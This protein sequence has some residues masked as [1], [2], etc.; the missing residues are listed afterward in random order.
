M[1]ELELKFRAETSQAKR[2]IR[3]LGDA[4]EETKESAG[5]LGAAFARLGDAAHRLDSIA[6]VAGDVIRMGEALAEAAA[7]AERHRNAL[8]RLGS[9]YDLVRNATNDMVSA[10]DA[11]RAQESLTQSGMRVTAEQL[12]VITQRAREYA[13]ATGTETTQA[14]DQLTDA[15]RGGEAE[16]LRRFG[17]SLAA[18][19]DRAT[20]FRTA[21]TQMRQAQEG[22]LP[23][24]RTLGE[25]LSHIRRGFT[26]GIGAMA[27]WVVEATGLRDVIREVSSAFDDQAHATENATARVEEGVTRMLSAI[28]T[29]R[30]QLAEA[31]GRAPSTNNELDVAI[32]GN[33]AGTRETYGRIGQVLGRTLRTTDL[34]AQELSQYEA[35]VTVLSGSAQDF[36]DRDRANA[37]TTQAE[38][39]QHALFRLAEAAARNSQN[40]RRPTTAAARTGG[41]SGSRPANDDLLSQFILGGSGFRD[42]MM[43]ANANIGGIGGLLTG[44]GGTWTEE[45]AADAALTAEVQA[46]ADRREQARLDEDKALAESTRRRALEIEQ[47]R[48]DEE[49]AARERNDLQTQL[50]QR[51]AQHQELNQTTA[52]NA[53]G[54]IEG[55]YNTM[56]GALKTH[57][58][59]VIQGKEDVGQAVKATLQ[60]ILLSLAAESATKAIMETAMGFAALARG[61]SSYGADAGAVVSAPMHFTSAAMFAAI[62]GAA[63]LGYAGVSAIG[64]G[65]AKSAG[66]FGAGASPGAAASTRGPGGAANDG[67]NVTIINNV[68]GFA[69]TH[70]GVQNAI[71]GGLEGYVGRGNRVR[72]LQ[73]A[74]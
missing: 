43:V 48:L 21:I 9:A 5:G 22:T 59:A 33:D 10:E 55:A 38:V 28:A 68:N 30:Q 36:D 60:E 57:I 24:T 11:L 65:E 53:A 41:G 72:G 32:L 15:L 14:L 6:S 54:L 46:N 2:D 64:G 45:M 61:A 47:Q 27:S 13:L 16:G 74:A 49:K 39:L 62:A 50:S 17:I 4:A 12:A 52:Q 29:A 44:I 69:M 66:G 56:T 70:E 18:G 25:D 51:F 19:T 26:E 34:N 3:E 71:A 20:A 67:G 42:S 23:S 1:A 31:E 63:G 8:T 40:T 58:A 7:D 35:A 37:Q 73:H